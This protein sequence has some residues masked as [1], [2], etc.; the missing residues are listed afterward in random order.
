MT[1]GAGVFDKATD[2]VAVAGVTLPA[3]EGAM[4]GV[5]HWAT[6]AIPILSVAWLMLRITRFV[7]D[8]RKG[9]A[10]AEDA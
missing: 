2:G 5:S 8:W 4:A 1:K 3:W 6:I 9:R 10:N 7:I